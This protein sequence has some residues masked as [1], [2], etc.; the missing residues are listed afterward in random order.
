[1]SSLKEG[2]KNLGPKTQK[3]T[4]TVSKPQTDTLADKNKPTGQGALEEGSLLSMV[5][6][7]A[8]DVTVAASEK[9]CSK[10]FC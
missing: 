10:V 6:S 3:L 4:E 7:Q 1:M 8:V 5:C 2:P 9:V